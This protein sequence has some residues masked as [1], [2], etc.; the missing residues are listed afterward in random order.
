MILDHVAHLLILFAIFL[1]LLMAINSFYFY[2]RYQKAIDQAV[3]KGFYYERGYLLC[4]LEQMMY[5]HYCLFPKRAKRDGFYEIFSV[6]EKRP[7]Q[8]LIFHWFAV[9]AVFFLGGIGA[10]ILKFYLGK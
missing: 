6:L 8:H 10:L 9:L 1:G 4:A 5:A 2:L 3:M 7:R